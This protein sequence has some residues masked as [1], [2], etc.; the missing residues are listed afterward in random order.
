MRLCALIF[1]RQ[2]IARLLDAIVRKTVAATSADNEAH[3]QRLFEQRSA[4]RPRSYGPRRPTG[5]AGRHTANASK[6]L[7]DLAR[8]C[9]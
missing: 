5:Q 4:A 8:R 9:R 1:V 6:L 2:R 3:L 7:H